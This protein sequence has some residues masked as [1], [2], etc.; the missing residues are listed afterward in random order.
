MPL[1]VCTLHYAVM[2]PGNIFTVEADFIGGCDIHRIWRYRKCYIPG[3]NV[4]NIKYVHL[5]LS[6]TSQ[7]AN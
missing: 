2:T 6:I 7:K 5:G 4:A 1:I 3:Q